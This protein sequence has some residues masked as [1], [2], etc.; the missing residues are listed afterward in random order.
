[1][2]AKS[3]LK[4]ILPISLVRLGSAGLDR[5]LP[6]RRRVGRQVLEPERWNR[7]TV[8]VT[9]EIVARNGPTVQAGPFAGLRL[10]T[11]RSWYGSL[12]PLFV[13]SYEAELHD[14][15]EEFIASKPLRV[16]NVGCAEGYYAV[17]LA[18]R[19]ANASIYAFDIDE[20]ARLLTYRTARMNG[21]S[22]RVHIAGA[23]TFH[24]LEE[25]LIPHTIVIMDCEGCELQ[26]LQPE[27]APSLQ[28][29]TLL[30]ELHDFVNPEISQTVLARFAAT[31]SSRIIHAVRRDP[32]GYAA[33][34]GLKR[35]DRV[36]AVDERRPTE[37]RP[38]EWVA[39]EPLHKS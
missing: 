13:G 3:L 33:L 4:R 9:S 12:A 32:T 36:L 38:M 2:S 30:V 37:P 16:V 25:I 24:R 7:A 29:A 19:I 18:R 34:D 35:S 31:H 20:R 22:A 23:C 5:T 15:I 26:L 8:R 27:N 28:Q 39:L 21:V 11:T 1:M 17:G 6:S 10:P 14:L